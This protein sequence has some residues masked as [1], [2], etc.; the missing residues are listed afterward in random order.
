[1]PD[2]SLLT[3]LFEIGVLWFLF[4][5]LYRVFKNSR[6]A[7]ILIGLIALVVGGGIFLE[8]FQAEV[9]KY[10]VSSLIGL[11]TILAVLFQPEIRMGLAKIGTKHFL[12][13]FGNHEGNQDFLSKVVDSTSWLASRRYGA[14]L[15]IA[16]SQNLDSY[17][18]TATPLDAEFSRELVGTIFMPKTLLHDGAVLV[19]NERILAA[20][21]ILPVTNRELKDTSMGLRHRAG[22]GLAEETDAVVIIVSEETGAISLAVG[23]TMERNVDITYLT[24]RLKELFNKQNYVEQN[25]KIS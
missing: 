9:L 13:L 19:H 14:L 1:M 6:G 8:L 16:R 3:A 18:A 22:I 21:A 23:S 25:K 2:Y 10:L 11:G 17:A 7:A 4:Y 15:A 12:H 20:A 5:Q 24:T